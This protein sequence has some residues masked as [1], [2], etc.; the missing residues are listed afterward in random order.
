[1]IRSALATK[2]GIN[3]NDLQNIKNIIFDL[4]GVI[5]NINYN[6]TIAAFRELQF[7]D[8]DKIFTQ[9][10]QTSLFDLLETGKIPP[11][12]FRNELRK[13]KHNLIDEQIDQA[14]NAMLGDLPPA[15]IDLLKSLRPEYRT[16]L[17]SNTNAIHIS[18]LMDY[19]VKHFGENLFPALFE[20]IFYSHEIGFR[21]PHTDA[22][23]FVLEKSG[24]NVHETLFIDD[25]AVNIEGARKAGLYAYHLQNE[26]ITDIFE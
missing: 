9:M 14:W 19:L 7:H 26:Y 25:L 3:T 4:G 15:N 6:N 12:T 17:L 8:F 11:Q 23:H 22:F 16:F 21:K 13:F 2:I 18:C 24:L 5:L 10:K 1:M 20:S